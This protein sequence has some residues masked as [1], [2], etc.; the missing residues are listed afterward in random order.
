MI[1]NEL[2]H[3]DFIATLGVVVAKP[4]VC[5]FNISIVLVAD[6]LLI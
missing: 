5:K 2:S 4:F 6:F 1:F 3:K